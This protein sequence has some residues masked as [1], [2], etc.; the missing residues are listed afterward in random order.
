MLHR[1]ASALRL[2]FA[3]FLITA[4]TAAGAPSR[5]ADPIIVLEHWTNFR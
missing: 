5:A 2:L 4:V 1:A 3:A